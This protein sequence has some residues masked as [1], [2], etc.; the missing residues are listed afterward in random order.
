LANFDGPQRGALTWINGKK[1]LAD[2][3][4]MHGDR[5]PLI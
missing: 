5:S 4:E 1:S 3:T 2:N